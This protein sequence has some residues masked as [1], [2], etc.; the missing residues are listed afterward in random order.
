MTVCL[1]CTHTTS[2]I[3]A[4][5]SPPTHTR[6]TAPQAITAD[7]TCSNRKVGEETLHRCGRSSHCRVLLGLMFT[8]LDIRAVPFRKPKQLKPSTESLKPWFR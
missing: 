3:Q 4:S 7:N 8:A 6:S 5:P 1:L 2:F